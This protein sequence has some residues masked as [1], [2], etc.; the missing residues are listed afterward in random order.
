MTKTFAPIL[1][2]SLPPAFRSIRLELARSPDHPAGDA[3]VAYIIL[4]PLDPNGRIDAD[5]WREHREACRVARLR[6]GKEQEIG[7]LVHRPGGAW[8]IHYEGDGAGPDETGYRFSEEQFVPG[9][10]VSVGEGN[11]MRTFKVITVNRL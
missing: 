9:E 7:H 2:A 5:L 4:A 11:D 10:Y 3:N 8:E 6:P 1:N